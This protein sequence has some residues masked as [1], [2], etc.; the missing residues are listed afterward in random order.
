[1]FKL[2]Q[3]QKQPNNQGGF[4]IIE[5]LMA[6]IVVSI[7]MIG[8]APVMAISVANRVQARRVEL[9]AGA[10]K[11]YVDGVRS[12][13][14]LPPPVTTTATDQTGA[15]NSVTL[16][17]DTTQDNI[18]RTPD[19]VNDPRDMG[20]CNPNSTDYYLYC[21]DGTGDNQ[22]TSDNFK[23]ML[24]QVFGYQPPNPALLPP[25]SDDGYLMGLRVYR[26]DAFVAG[27]TLK[28]AQQGT[29]VAAANTGGTGLK[30]DVAP[31]VEM[32]TEVVDEDTNFSDLCELT[33]KTNT[34]SCN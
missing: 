11:S 12:G 16:N 24:V 3:V 33:D 20:Y 14:I 29:K 15:P 9:A 4:T 2:K 13:S 25:N 34:L 5:S 1:M 17:C 23:D 30:D 6:I 19:T 28:T 18:T 31:L 32:T 7:L 21:V 8:I 22:C 26:S 27:K 10:A